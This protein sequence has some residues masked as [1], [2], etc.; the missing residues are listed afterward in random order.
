LD[1]PVQAVLCPARRRGSMWRRWVLRGRS[2][3]EIE[4]LRA[5]KQCL[6]NRPSSWRVCYPLGPCPCPCRG[7]ARAGRTV[8]EDQH[9][10]NNKTMR[11]FYCRSNS[12]GD[13]WGRGR[14]TR[15]LKPFIMVYGGARWCEV[16]GGAVLQGKGPALWSAWAQWTSL[17]C[18][19]AVTLAE[20]ST[21]VGRN[22]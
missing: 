5:A 14:T 2:Q 20:D 19:A 16:G 18:W 22:W 21:A 15:C 13:W 1:H 10:W 9:M 11:H 3:Q 6:R 12:G 4:R 17:Y 7:C 8:R